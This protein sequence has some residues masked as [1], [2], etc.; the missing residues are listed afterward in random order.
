MR[1]VVAFPSSQARVDGVDVQAWYGLRYAHAPRRFAAAE[2]AS[3][4]LA[5]QCLQQV[6]VFPQLPSRLA[7]AMGSG[8]ANPQDEDAFFLNVWAPAQAQGLPVLLFIHGGAWMTG[9][10]SMAWYDGTRLAAQGLV[11]VNVNYRLGAL[12]HLGETQAHDLPLPAIDLLLALQWVAG[13]V[14]AYGGDA[15]RITLMGQSAGGWYAHLL[16]VLPQTRGM[17]HRVALLSMGARQPWPAQRQRMVTAAAATRIAELGHGVADLHTAPAEQVL[18]AG[19]SALPYEPFGLGHAPAAFLPVASAGL[20]QGLLEPGWAAQA[21]HARAV[22]LRHTA[23]ECAAFFFQM[24]AQRQATQQQVD[25]ALAGWPTAELPPS[26]CS[27]GQ[28]SGAQSGLSPYRQLVAAASWRQFQRFTHEYAKQLWQL[29]KPVQLARFTLES[30][31]D[32]FH[33]GHCLDLPF[34]FGQLTAW[35]DAPM[36]VGLQPE[37]LEAVSRHWMSDIV[38][39]TVRDLA[40]HAPANGVPFAT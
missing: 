40:P 35:A 38:N 25:E 11:V 17:L 21:C 30:P 4:Q 37:L 29:G 22:Y 3:G 7:A 6:P 34:Q 10:G 2:A 5:V 14:H 18:R 15:G 13:H 39:F 28:F 9:G 24:P 27:Q 31:L 16:S 32:G 36:L 1:A 8:G 23:D 33:S 26:L 12:G 20:P 19:L